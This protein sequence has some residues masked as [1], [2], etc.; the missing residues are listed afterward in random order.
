MLNAVDEEVRRI[1]DECYAEAR[2]LLKDNR[3]KLD[4][5]VTQLLVHETLDERG[6]LC[7]GRNRASRARGR[8]RRNCGADYFTCLTAPRG[9]AVLMPAPA[10]SRASDTSHIEAT[11]M[12]VTRT[13]RRWPVQNS[14]STKPRWPHDP[15]VTASANPP[16]ARA[17]SGLTIE[18]VVPGSDDRP[19][20]CLNQR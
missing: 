8:P 10:G 17:P 15:D 3:D 2:R 9:H 14:T 4:A 20:R 13:I 7:R 12:R 18:P 6:R 16:V 5:I 19:R 11:H 1:T